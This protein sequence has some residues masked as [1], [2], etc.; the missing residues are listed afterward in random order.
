MGPT[1]LAFTT[2]DLLLPLGTLTGL[3]V[4][5]CP[6]AAPPSAPFTFVPGFGAACPS[7]PTDAAVLLGI[8][9]SPFESKVIGGAE[10]TGRCAFDAFRFD[11]AASGMVVGACFGGS[12]LGRGREEAGAKPGT[13]GRGMAVFQ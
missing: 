6:A 12:S 8:C 1:C 2:I 4:F 7:L 9:A 5:S 3:L 10:G 11:P 13:G